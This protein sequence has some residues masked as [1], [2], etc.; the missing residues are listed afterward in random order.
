MR[1]P[2]FRPDRPTMIAM[3]RRWIDGE[4]ETLLAWL[5]DVTHRPT[6]AMATVALFAKKQGWPSA[7][8][9]RSCA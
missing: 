2:V 9:T 8:R 5:R 1:G 3:R 4:R 7:Y 6:L